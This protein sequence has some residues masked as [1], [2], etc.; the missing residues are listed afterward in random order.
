MDTKEA[1]GNMDS[2]TRRLVLEL[3]SEY[4]RTNSSSVLQELRRIFKNFGD[5]PDIRELA[6]V[7]R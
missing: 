7:L 2:N 5:D 3:Y 6:R 1:W 4:Q